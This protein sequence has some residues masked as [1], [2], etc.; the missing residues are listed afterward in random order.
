MED[1]GFLGREYRTSP[2]SD[3]ASRMVTFPPAS[4]MAMPAI[5]PPSP[6][7][8][9]PIL[10]E[11]FWV[12]VMVMMILMPFSRNLVRKLVLAEDR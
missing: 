8:I 6:A 10:S 3:A 7:P 5:K 2:N 12:S 4:A 1:K 9:I 11:F